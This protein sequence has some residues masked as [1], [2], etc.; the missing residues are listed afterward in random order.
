[1]RI[2]P[3]ADLRDIVWASARVTLENG[4]EHIALIPS[5]YPGTESA[6][7]DS[8]KLARRTEWKEIGTDAFAGLGQ[9]MLA[10]DDAEFALLDIRQIDIR[11]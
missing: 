4:G 2:E 7:D 1:V 3:P 9:R 6:A 8:L 10:T 11:A 5:R